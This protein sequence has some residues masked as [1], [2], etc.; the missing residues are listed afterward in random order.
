MQ[1]TPAHPDPNDI[2]QGL[3]EG[4][5]NRGYV[6]WRA[7]ILKHPRKQD[8]F[9]RVILGFLARA[10]WTGRA[11]HA[12]WIAG[13][14]PQSA[15]V[16]RVL[17]ELA[18]QAALLVQDRQHARAYATHDRLMRY[19]SLLKLQRFAKD[20]VAPLNPSV[21]EQI[22]DLR[23]FYD[24]HKQEFLRPGKSERLWDNWWKGSIADLANRMRS[25]PDYGESLYHEYQFGYDVGSLYTHSTGR[26][27]EDFMAFD[28]SGNPILKEPTRGDEPSAP[29]HIVRRLYQLYIFFDMALKLG[30][31][32]QLKED[33]EALNEAMRV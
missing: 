21:P 7:A 9:E 25:V 11:V 29:F 22:A 24:A 13:Y 31:E 32:S 8:T 2:A 4:S 30:E 16:G 5:I 3:L 28:E 27:T 26:V 33:W 15:V 19:R 18:L 23:P 1:T 10:L 20:G 17:I 14:G 12:L 6:L